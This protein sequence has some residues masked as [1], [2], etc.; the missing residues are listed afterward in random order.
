MT[1]YICNGGCEG[2]S[3]KPGACQAEHCPD[4]GK[5]L[6]ACDCPD[7]S[8]ENSPQSAPAAAKKETD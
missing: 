7:N 3:D 2:V 1:H 8:H 5:E 6:H 4:H